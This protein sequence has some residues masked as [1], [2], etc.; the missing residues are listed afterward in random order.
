MS[1]FGFKKK[2]L[3]SQR[4]FG[5][6]LRIQRKRKK[7]SLAQAEEETKIRA[8]Y[9]HALEEGNL[10]DL[11]GEIY[12]LGFLKK[13]AQYL[14]MDVS[15]IVD[16]YKREKEIL[17]KLGRTP[18]PFKEVSS[19]KKI[20]GTRFLITPKIIAIVASVALILGF[21]GYIIFEV[22][23]FAKPP[24]L[25]ISTPSLEEIVKTD[26]VIVSGTTDPGGELYINNNLIAIDE[27]GNFSQE[28]K[29]AIGLNLIEVRARN[30]LGKETDKSIKVLAQ[31]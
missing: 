22:N 30:R 19:A 25:S 27:N 7:I 2:K 4:S 31:Y 10:S 5:Q 13:Y 14:K 21:L 29:L 18:I 16:Q 20:S 17:Q 26:K 3:S 15:S 23:Q 1:S 6:R 8:H 28:I 9:L 11:P 24:V 12:T